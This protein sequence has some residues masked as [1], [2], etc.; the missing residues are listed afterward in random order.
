MYRYA[1]RP[2]SDLGQVSYRS[3]W[4]RVILQVLHEH[5]GK[6]SVP[7]ISRVTVGLALLTS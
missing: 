3:Y 6:I 4:S 1:A 2:L 5:K 7:E